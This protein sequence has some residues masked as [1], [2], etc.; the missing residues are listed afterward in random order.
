MPHQNVFCCQ[1]NSIHVLIDHIIPKHEKVASN[2]K[3]NF[4]SHYFRRRTLR[5]NSVR[6]NIIVNEKLSF[7]KR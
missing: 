2:N 5:E 7:S 1:F 3:N 4:F 6:E